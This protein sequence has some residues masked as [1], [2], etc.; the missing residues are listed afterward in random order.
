M[1][2]NLAAL[3]KKKNQAAKSH[4]AIDWDSRRQSYLDAVEEL[5]RQIEEIL[6]E[7]IRQGLVAVRRRPKPLTESFIGNYSVDDLIL[8]IGDE[9]VRFSPRGRNIAGAEGR[10]DV[11]GERQE[12]TLVLQKDV[13]WGV[14]ESRQPRLRIEPLSEST[15]SEVLRLVMRD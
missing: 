4:D 12:V 9:Q 7:S 14:V 5:Y 11:I 2:R 8:V 3:L 15:L 6:A 10:V 13:G 1:D